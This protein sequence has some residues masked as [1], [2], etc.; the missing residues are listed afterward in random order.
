MER[1]LAAPW[2]FD[3]SDPFIE[4]L[5]SQII[6]FSIDLERLEGKWKLTRTIR[7]NAG[8]ASMAALRLGL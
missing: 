8:A 6:G 3:S 2:Q 7:Q 1:P 5:A 4:K